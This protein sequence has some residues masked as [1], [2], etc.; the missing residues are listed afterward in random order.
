MA[1]VNMHLCKA[2]PQLFIKR[3][4]QLSRACERNSSVTEFHETYKGMLILNHAF[5]AFICNKNTVP[6]PV[7][8]H[9]VT[10]VSLAWR[11]LPFFSGVWHTAQLYKLRNQAGIHKGHGLTGLR[12]I[13]PWGDP[14]RSEHLTDFTSSFVCTFR[15]E[16]K[17]SPH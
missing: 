16:K 2:L 12:H 11:L 13:V 7:R 17:K 15:E 10:S 4:G 9:A 6:I 14:L 5:R 8:F 1:E 3:Q